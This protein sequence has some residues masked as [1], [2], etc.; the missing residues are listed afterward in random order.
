MEIE[1][2]VSQAFVVTVSAEQAP[3][4]HAGD[5]AASICWFRIVSE[6]TGSRVR[7]Y[8]SAEDIAFSILLELE[9]KGSVKILEEGDNL[10]FDHSQIIA[11]AMIAAGLL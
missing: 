11:D 3:F 6:R 4:A 8:F 2:F 9:V 7:V 10:A 1:L 5:D